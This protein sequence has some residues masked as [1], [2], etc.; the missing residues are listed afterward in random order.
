MAG[1]FGIDVPDWGY[2]DQLDNARRLP[3]VL[4]FS[5]LNGLFVN[6][7]VERLGEVLTTQAAGVIAYVSATAKSYVAQNNLLGDRLFN[8]FFSAGNLEFGPALDVAKAQLLAAHYSYDA[9]ALT[10]QLFGD[11]AQKLALPQSADR[12]AGMI[13]TR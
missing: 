6:P 11:P 1:V 13:A 4:A 9:A 2:L 10:M 8:Q 3:L 12:L 7:K 5:C